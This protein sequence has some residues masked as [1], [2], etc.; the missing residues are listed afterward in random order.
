MGVPGGLWAVLEGPTARGTRGCAR[1]GARDRA[2]GGPQ[3]HPT[4][5][6]APAG[7]GRAWARSWAVL[8]ALEAAAGSS[9]GSRGGL[10]ASEG[11]QDAH[12]GGAP[13]A[14]SGR[15]RGGWGA[16]EGELERQ[17]RRVLHYQI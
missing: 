4:T 11:A 17:P 13:D 15:L 6:P 9:G 12:A 2:Q 10:R 3:R 7:L 14:C 1:R 5:S 16:W 8:R